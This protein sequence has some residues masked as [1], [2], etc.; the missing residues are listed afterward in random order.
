MNTE[1]V[2]ASGMNYSHLVSRTTVR[3]CSHSALSSINEKKVTAFTFLKNEF[4][5]FL[6][7]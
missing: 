2:F 5:Y 3:S 4:R 7:N 1:S 6:V